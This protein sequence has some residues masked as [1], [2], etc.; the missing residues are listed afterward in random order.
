MRVCPECKNRFEDAV[1]RCPHDGTVLVELSDKD[2]TVMVERQELQRLQALEVGRSRYTIIERIGQGG[3]GGVYRAYQHSTRREVALK[4]LRRDVAE[5]ISARRRFHREAEAISRLKH[6]NTVTIFD[7]GET[8]DGLL[9]IAMEYVEGTSLDQAIRRDGTIA[10]L[11]AASIA[12]QV[13]LSLAEAHAKGIVH[14]DIKPQNIMLAA[15]EDGQE[16]VK[17]LDF[18]VAKIVGSDTRLTST[19]STFGTPEY[20]SPEQVQSRDL[21]HRS[22]L[23]SLGIVLYE[24]LTG[25]PP[26]SGNS[27]VTVALSHV[28]TRP[29]PI[30]GPL[31]M[32]ESLASLTRRLLAKQ[33]SERGGAAADVAR[34]LEA[35]EL[36]LKTGALPPRRPGRVLRRFLAGAVA[37]WAAGVTVLAVV[38]AISAAFLVMR[39]RLRERKAAEGREVAAAAGPSG[40]E[41]AAREVGGERSLEAPQEG[42][43]GERSL[44]APQEGGGGER[45]LETP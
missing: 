10:P 11:R 44:E 31:D 40:R 26:F 16:I 1:D 12:R 8:P 28:R 21:D 27:A 2:G 24:M 19:G 18:G 25:A 36:E 41:E 15:H 39:E 9:F 43:G 23:Y 7:F 13:A 5:D 42:G 35:I 33:P 38:C 30:K 32:P 3:W 29:P 37:H 22:D 6:P 14:R 20:M 45:S 17:V 34:D 4:V